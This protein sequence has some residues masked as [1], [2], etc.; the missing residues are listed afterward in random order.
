MLE[1]ISTLNLLKLSA[2]SLAVQVALTGQVFA[3]EAEET[4][5][6]YINIE[7]EDP[8]DLDDFLA[9]KSKQIF[10]EWIK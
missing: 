3:Q 9:E 5:E 8:V 1:R 10:E 7:D 2:L 4:E 6:E